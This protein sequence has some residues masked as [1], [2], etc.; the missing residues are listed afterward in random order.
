MRMLEGMMVSIAKIVTLSWSCSCHSHFPHLKVTIK[1]ALPGRVLSPP[2]WCQWAPGHRWQLW[3]TRMMSRYVTPGNLPVSH[4][5]CVAL[6]PVSRTR[7]VP[8]APVAA[9]ASFFYRL[10]GDSGGDAQSQSA[11]GSCRAN[12]AHSCVKCKN[13]TWCAA[14]TI[15]TMHLHILAL[16]WPA[17][18][19]LIYFFLWH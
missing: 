4:V 1:P 3:V 12:I 8:P 14:V 2:A 6:F 13:V 19:H 5:T 17:W 11:P 7:S 16:L 10:G 9:R 15:L 18:Q